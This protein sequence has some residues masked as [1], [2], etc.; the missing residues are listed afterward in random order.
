MMSELTELTV[1]LTRNSPGG[2]W[3]AQVLEVPGCCAA[4][5]TVCEALSNLAEVIFYRLIGIFLTAEPDAG[6]EQDC[7]EDDDA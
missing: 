7:L 1:R 5:G 6:D 3:L 2:R 4:G